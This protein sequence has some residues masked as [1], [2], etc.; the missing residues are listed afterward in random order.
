M[1]DVASQARILNHLSYL[2]FQRGDFEEAAGIAR[3]ALSLGIDLEHKP[4]IATA[5]FNQANA[6]RNQGDY[7]EAIVS[8]EQAA[9]I[10]EQ[11]D[12]QRRLADCLNR[13][14]EPL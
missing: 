14:W 7:R 4:E 12:D 10:F 13:A 8:Y 3:Q 6:L 11:L 2:R 9:A 1:G 5:L